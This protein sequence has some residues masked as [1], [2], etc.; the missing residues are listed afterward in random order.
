[1]AAMARALQ[2]FASYLLSSEART[3]WTSVRGRITPEEGELTWEIFKNSFLEK[4]FPVDAKGR[5]EMEFLELKQEAMSVGEYAAKFEELC[6][7]NPHYNAASDET[8]K[9]VKIF[10]ENEKT[11]KEYLKGLG[12]NK[13]PRKKEEKRKPYFRPQDQGRNQ[14]GRTWNPTRGSGF[15]GRPGGFNNTPF[16]ARCGSNG[17]RAQECRVVLGRQSG[18]QTG[19]SGNPNPTT[20]VGEGSNRN[21]NVT[22]RDN[23]RVGRSAIKG[24]VFAMTVEEASESPE[25]IEGATHSFISHER[26]KQLGFPVTSLA[27]DSEIST[28]TKNTSRTSKLPLE[29]RDILNDSNIPVRI[30]RNVK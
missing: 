28:P 13:A 22:P 16:C 10:E 27:W 11:R 29:M 3:W 20:T 1:M 6:R 15:Q 7:F 26:V 30:I 21:A 12:V 17:H 23:R 18:L 5:K 25:L 8:S 19:G 14:F 9:C 4:Y 24:K 2:A